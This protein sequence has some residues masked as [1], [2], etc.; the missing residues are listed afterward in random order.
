MSLQSC[1]PS[2]AN[3]ILG[4]WYTC[5][6]LCCSALGCC[7]VERGVACC[8]AQHTAIATLTLRETCPLGTPVQI[9][10]AACLYHVYYMYYVKL[11]V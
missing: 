4:I 8:T 3:T 7:A 5:E 1:P 6:A 2:A 10:T 11:H 9:R